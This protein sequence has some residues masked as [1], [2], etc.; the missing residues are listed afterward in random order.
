[1]LTGQIGISISI[2]ISLSLCWILISDH[3]M[4]EMIFEVWRIF[5]KPGLILWQVTEN[6]N[7]NQ[8]KKNCLAKYLG[9][10][11]GK[12]QNWRK[13]CKKQGF[14]VWN[15]GLNDGRNLFLPIFTH[16]FHYMFCFIRIFPYVKGHGHGSPSLA[17][18]LEQQLHS[19]FV[20][21]LVPGKIV[22]GQVSEMGVMGR[23]AGVGQGQAQSVT[24]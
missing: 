16:V 18:P 17:T 1:M 2:L 22:I 4:K 23:F 10:I 21:L 6:L 3:Y 15:Q 5:Y 14:N 13:R 7:S 9:R 12:S 19:L 11:L 24:L 20:H 8:L